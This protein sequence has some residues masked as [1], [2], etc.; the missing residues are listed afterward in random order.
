MQFIPL[1]PEAFIAKPIIIP[2]KT[3]PR[4]AKIRIFGGSLYHFCFLGILFNSFK[5]P[6]NTKATIMVNNKKLVYKNLIC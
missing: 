1:F 4:V 2:N 5:D 3:I 6:K